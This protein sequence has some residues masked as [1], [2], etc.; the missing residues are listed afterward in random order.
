MQVVV[1]IEILADGALPNRC[2]SVTFR[3]AQTA[4]FANGLNVHD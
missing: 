4:L 3:Q 1:A 2:V